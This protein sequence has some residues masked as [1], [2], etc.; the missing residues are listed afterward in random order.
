VQT[1]PCPVLVINRYRELHSEALTV[2]MS[3]MR[4]EY[5]VVHSNNHALYL[6][7]D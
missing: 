4:P 6:D 7:G 2:D 1:A 5:E 3:D